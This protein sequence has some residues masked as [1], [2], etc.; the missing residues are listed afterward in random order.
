MKNLKPKV[1]FYMDIIHTL[2]PLLITSKV[3]RWNF[4]NSKSK[5]DT[6][7]VIMMHED[8]GCQLSD[9][10]VFL[11]H[12]L[13]HLELSAVYLSSAGVHADKAC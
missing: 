9:L 7:D 1:T 5:T 4:S 6:R 8:S 13:I 10:S 12:L 2:L 3:N 11:Q